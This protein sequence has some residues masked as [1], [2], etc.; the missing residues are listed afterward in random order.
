LRRLI[1]DPGLRK[2]LGAA[3]EARVRGHFD[4]HASIDQLKALFEAARSAR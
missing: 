1:S 2:Q 3:A 4:H